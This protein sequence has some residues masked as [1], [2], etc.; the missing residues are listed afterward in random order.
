VIALRIVI[1]GI[2]LVANASVFVSDAPPLWA[3]L[4]F[5]GMALVARKYIAVGLI[6]ISSVAVA[7][8]TLLYQIAIT[9]SLPPASVLSTYTH[10][11]YIRLFSYF[12]IPTILF[13]ALFNLYDVLPTRDRHG[14]RWL[15]W[16]R[17]ALIQV[18]HRRDAVKY[19]AAEIFE[20]LEIRGLATKGTINRLFRAPTWVP[21]LIAT[22]FIE[23]LEA[24]AYERMM[25]INLA[26]YRGLYRQRMESI[27][28]I[29]CLDL[30][31]LVLAGAL[32]VHVL[33]S[34]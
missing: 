16:G 10:F 24:D 9:G 22:L 6:L 21:I 11:G 27:L 34:N 20:A 18:A 2:L 7:L 12:F 13:S 33:A 19:R 8:T 32:V 3:V 17:V 25:G 30:L 26:S 15:R 28:V 29:R 5:I 4:V 31:I 23:A 1:F 14:S